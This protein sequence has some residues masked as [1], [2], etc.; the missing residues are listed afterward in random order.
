[1]RPEHIG[2]EEKES[3]ARNPGKISPGENDCRVKDDQHDTERIAVPKPSKPPG[4]GRYQSSMASLSF[5]P[6]ELPFAPLMVS[7]IGIE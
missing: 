4:Y 6:L 3:N 5:V 7:P 2:T 1:M